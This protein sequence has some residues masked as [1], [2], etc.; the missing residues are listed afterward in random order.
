MTADPKFFKE[1]EGREI[2]LIIKGLSKANT[3]IVVLW[4]INSFKGI[5]PP[6]GD[7][8]IGSGQGVGHDGGDHEKSFRGSREEICVSSGG[9]SGSKMGIQYTTSMI[10]P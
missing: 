6:N 9:D 8:Q 7:V 10:N 3:L 5:I 4:K 1:I 2:K